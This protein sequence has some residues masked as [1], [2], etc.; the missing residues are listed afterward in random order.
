MRIVELDQWRGPS[1][2]CGA[3]IRADV[4]TIDPLDDD[5]V[6]SFTHGAVVTDQGV[7]GMWGHDQRS[8]RAT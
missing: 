2:R 8:G 7:A 4:S 5:P 6:T 1:W 3:G